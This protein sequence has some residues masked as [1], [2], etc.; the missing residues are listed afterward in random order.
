MKPDRPSLRRNFL[1][2]TGMHLLIL[3]AL[4][5]ATGLQAWLRH[6]KPLVL[7]DGIMLEVPVNGIPDKETVV[8]EP[9]QPPEP[10]AA[11]EPKP[12][13]KPPKP[14]PD[15]PGIALKAK[16]TPPKP[17]DKQKIEV[18]RKRVRRPASSETTRSATRKT[19]LS[20]EEVRKLLDMGARPGN[21]STLTD[22]EM[23]RLIGS[24][25]R[26]GNQGADLSRDMLYLEIIRQTLYRAWDQPTSADI[27]GLTAKVDISILPNGSIT[28]SRLVK[29]SGS[30]VMDES[31]MR[32]V[33]SVPAVRGVPP[34][35]LADHPTLTVVFE[36]TGKEL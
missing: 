6:R 32:A 25:M 34:A 36:L 12:E 11:P 24:G 7:S 23:R 35:F 3:M 29:N 9:K 5:V 19:R 22:E 28:G 16:P 26:F 18:S 2:V 15:D 14:E 10:E 13:P 33:R 21:R 31:V 1:A 20:Q 17:S 30:P 4:C 27:D 8:A